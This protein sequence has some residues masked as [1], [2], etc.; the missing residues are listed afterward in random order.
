MTYIAD[1]GVMCG[2]GIIEFHLVIISLHFVVNLDTMIGRG[3]QE[4]G[5]VEVMLHC[6]DDIVVSIVHGVR[7]E[8]SD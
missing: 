1:F 2:P 5:T 7:P 3:S 4:A 8:C 6:R